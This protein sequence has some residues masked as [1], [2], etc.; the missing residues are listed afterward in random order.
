MATLKH[1]M[2]PFI[3]KPAPKEEPV[4]EELTREISPHLAPHILKQDIPIKVPN[5]NEFY[6]SLGTK[7]GWRYVVDAYATGTITTTAGATVTT[8]VSLA[9]PTGT[10]GNIWK[11][12][13]WPG[14]TLLFPVLRFFSFGPQTATFATQGEINLLFID[15][16]GN[17]CPLGIA[18]NNG[19]YAQEL[20]SVMPGS[21]TD[22]GQQ[23]NIGVLSAT[24]NAG[25]TTGT[26]AWQIGLSAAYLL[27]ALKGYDIEFIG[28][29][30]GSAHHD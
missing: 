21:I 27:P 29:K 12:E 30:Y 10:Q 23:L 24:L 3:P 7:Q 16:F 4:H 13:R 5:Y 8:T 17:P 14:G 26:Y 25:A 18:P 9:L 28:E 2:N 22:S 11:L 6:D 20:L 15:Q 19:F 1:K